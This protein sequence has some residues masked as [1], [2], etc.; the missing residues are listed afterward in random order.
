[1]SLRARFA[2]AFALVGAI[3]SGS[4]GALSYHA[5]VERITSEIDRSL[6]SISVAVIN[7]Q[8]RVLAAQDPLTRRV[9][10]GLDA[11]GR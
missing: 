4:V 7:G 9:P 2:F 11:P 8:E 5:A 3:V 6:Q 1:V 10:R